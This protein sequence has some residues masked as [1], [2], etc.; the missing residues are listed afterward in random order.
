MKSFK[1]S[2]L[3][4]FVFLIMI[5]IASRLVPHQWNMTAVG[6]VSVVAGLLIQNRILKILVPVIALLV[7]DLVIGF[8]STVPFVY[9]GFTLMVLMGSLFS[10]DS[11][12]KKN[13]LAPLAGSLIFFLVSNFG[14][15]AVESGV[16]YSKDLSGLFQCYLMG[17]PFYKTQFVADLILTPFLLNVFVHVLN[18]DFLGFRKRI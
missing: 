18:F 16:A 4:L 10:A 11:Q 6:A 7:T 1:S 5:A 15:W 12:W 13:L 9:G 3:F 17:V 8:H 14:V 2:D